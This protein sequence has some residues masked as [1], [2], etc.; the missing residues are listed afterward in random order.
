MWL[1]R[2]TTYAENH[3]FR[4]WPARPL[5]WL[6]RG[7]VM[8]TGPLRRAAMDLFE[9]IYYDSARSTWDNTSWMGIACQK[10]PTD[11]WVYQEILFQNK[12]ELVVETGTLS[13]GSALFFA[14]LFDLMGQRQVI[15]IDLQV[16][17]DRPRHPR[18]RYISGLSSTSPE[19]VEQL[20]PA[21][22]R[23]SRRI[24]I[25][26][27]DHWKSHVDEELRI[28]SQFVTPG[29]YLIVEDSAVNGQPISAQFG[30]GPFESIA[31]FVRH[32]RRFAVDKSKEKFFLSAN[33]NGFLLR[34]K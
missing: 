26:D 19:V 21:L 12:P 13:G 25:L 11:L 9:N 2:P 8:K 10:Y 14:S 4:R 17:R 6:I 30:P 31:A 27:S 24:V 20:L 5:L 32:N 3:S 34:V 33:H 1:N 28:Y 29:Q 15:S 7:I 22:D 23:T 16:R 18:I